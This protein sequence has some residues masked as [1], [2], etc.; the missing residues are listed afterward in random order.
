MK[1]SECPKDCEF[2]PANDYS[3][4][5]ANCWVLQL[6]FFPKPKAV[7]VKLGDFTAVAEY[8]DMYLLTDG[9]MVHK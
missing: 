4:A 8:G 5:C 9:T 6:E 1:F 3:L 2:D 7:S